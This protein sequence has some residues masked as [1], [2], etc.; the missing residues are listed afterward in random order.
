MMPVHGEEELTHFHMRY[1]NSVDEL[2]SKETWFPTF[3]APS[4]T[5]DQIKD[6]IKE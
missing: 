6:E 3:V 2:M 5:I 1:G 4:S